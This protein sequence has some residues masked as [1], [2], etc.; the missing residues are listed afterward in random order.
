MTAADEVRMDANNSPDPAPVHQ[1]PEPEHR[2][3]AFHPDLG[4]E[5]ADELVHACFGVFRP[6]GGGVITW[7]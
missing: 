4:D 6:T 3:R 2:P 5:E 1:S 7:R